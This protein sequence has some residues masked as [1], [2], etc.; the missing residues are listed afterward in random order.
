MKPIKCRYKAFIR[1][2]LHAMDPN[3]PSTITIEGTGDIVHFTSKPGFPTK[4]VVKCVGS[5]KFHECD[6]EDVYAID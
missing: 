6:L 4:A 2:P 5:G 3:K 1:N